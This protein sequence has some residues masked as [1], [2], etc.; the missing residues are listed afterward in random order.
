MLKGSK[1]VAIFLTIFC[2]LYLRAEEPL[3]FAPILGQ[4]VAFAHSA[5]TLTLYHSRAKERAR[6]DK[7]I[8]ELLGPEV[9]SDL[10]STELS[11]ELPTT[12]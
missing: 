9:P 3:A 12:K 4:E 7:L 5:S 11:S 2:S 6:V 10:S 8:R 1:A